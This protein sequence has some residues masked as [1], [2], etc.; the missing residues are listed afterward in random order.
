L[1]YNDMNSARMVA[2]KMLEKVRECNIPH[3]ANDISNFVTISIG[4]TTDVI[5]H[6][7]LGSDFIK[8]ADEALYE[9]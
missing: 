8:A 5:N 1:P 3:E 4:S 9:S 2:E 7:Q 6:L